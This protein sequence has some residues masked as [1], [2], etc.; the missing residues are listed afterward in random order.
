M[1]E[2]EGRPRP[3]PIPTSK[4]F[5]DALGEGEVR[6]Q[7]C[8][9]CGRWV[10]YPRRRCTGCLSDALVWERVSGHGRLY[11]YTV[12]RQATHP[13]FAA[14]VPQFLAVVELDEGVR[15]TTT[16]VDATEGELVVGR[17]VEPVFDTGGDGMTLLRFRLKG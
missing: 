8:A 5:W 11:S 1:A 14:D 3:A 4:P 16:L 12:A 13:A 10:Y 17:E 7:H 15:L 2:F 6:L 9:D